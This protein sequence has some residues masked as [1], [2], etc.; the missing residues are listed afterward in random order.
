MIYR[1]IISVCTYTSN[2]DNNTISVRNQGDDST[3]VTDWA[4]EGE[5]LPLLAKTGAGEPRY[6]MSGI[7]ISN[8]DNGE[9]TL[10]STP[11]NIINNLN[12]MC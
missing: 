7:T 11:I 8:I 9:I 4:V 5:E 2:I 1:I 10:N 12:N 3:N 6:C